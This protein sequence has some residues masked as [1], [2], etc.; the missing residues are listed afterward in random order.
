MTSIQL[1][2]YQS[3]AVD[4]LIENC[5]EL[6]D[7]AVTDQETKRHLFQAPTGS[8][9]TVVCGEF[10]REWMDKT[11]H[12]C[13]FIWVAPNKLHNQSYNKLKKQLENTKI[14]CVSY[15]ELNG[16]NIIKKNHIIFFNWA[17]INRENNRII[18]GGERGNSLDNIVKNTR[19]KNQRIVS[20]I[21][22]GHNTAAGEQS[23]RVRNIINSN[24]EIFVTATPGNLAS[25]CDGHTRIKRKKVVEDGMICESIF[26]NEDKKTAAATSMEPKDV[27]ANGLTE[28]SRLA[29]LY[30]DE[31]ILGKPA[32]NP[33]MLIQL[34]DQNQ[35]AIANERDKIEKILKDNHNITTT[36]GKLAIYLSDDNTNANQTT[37][38]KKVQKR[39]KKNLDDTNGLPKGKNIS[40]NDSGVEVLIFNKQLH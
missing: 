2:E 18:I 19:K 20:F 24:L 23:A 9:K 5:E 27:L 12:N 37:A 33:L 32:V 29:K 39:N 10:V 34:P 36:N 8:G 35:N 16:S 38:W 31:Q 25:Q 26:F 11:N 6:L 1:K 4:D 14:K 15:D 28:R 30:K 21:D 17:S 22:E 3:D 40:D 13:S 7:D